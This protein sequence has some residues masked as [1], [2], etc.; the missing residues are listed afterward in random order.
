MSKLILLIAATI[1]FVHLFLPTPLRAQENTSYH[2]LGKWT[3]ITSKYGYRKN[4]FNKKKKAQFHKGIDLAIK[5]GDPVYAWR[6]GTIASIGRSKISGN[7]INVQHADGYVSK[8]HH[9]HKVL[10]RKGDIV[11]AG[12]QIAQAGRTG[13]VTGPHLHFTI[14]KSGKYLNPYP[15]LRESK[16]VEQRIAP[17]AMPSTV[18][19]EFLVKSYPVEGKVFLDGEYKGK[20]PLNLKLAYGEYFIEVEPGGGYDSHTERVWIGQD[21]NSLYTARV[22]RKSNDVVIE[23]ISNNAPDDD[24][25]EIP[26]RTRRYSASR[27]FTGLTAS[28]NLLSPEN[29]PFASRIG[30]ALGFDAGV[31]GFLAPSLVPRIDQFLDVRF[32]MMRGSFNSEEYFFVLDDG[33]INGGSTLQRLEDFQVFAGSIGYYLAPRITR[34]FSLLAGGEL[35]Y[36]VMEVRSYAQNEALIRNSG[37][38]FSF[39]EGD[40]ELVSSRLNYFAPAWSVGAILFV[41]DF[42]AIQGKYHQ[43]F[44]ASNT[45]WS[46]FKVG[47]ITNLAY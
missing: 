31:G 11:N 27:S 8:Y 4:P 43:T 17:P 16:R 47:I 42:V 38:P 39:G 23:D 34:S 18:Q 19:K 30:N 25:A 12:Q 20:T 21:S 44:S 33:S 7:I 46:G 41:N 35:T 2:P 24:F 26:M 10:V 40:V 32:S 6:S 22:E 15:Y 37:Q 29:Q 45:E 14:T 1:F 9:L 5:I 28:A 36:G 3:M 13:K